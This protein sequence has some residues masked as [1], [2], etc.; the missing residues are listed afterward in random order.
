MSVLCE[1]V[2]C[3][4]VHEINR[5]SNLNIIEQN[6][7]SP[8]IYWANGAHAKTAHCLLSAYWDTRRDEVRRP[9]FWEKV[10]QDPERHERYK[11]ALR[12]RMRR[13]RASRSKARAAALKLK[14]E[15][16]PTKPWH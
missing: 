16:N 3:E 2:L 4:R 8:L 9:T 13:L 7:H 11:A 12:E 15:T 10:L 5:H 6:E 1:A 14:S